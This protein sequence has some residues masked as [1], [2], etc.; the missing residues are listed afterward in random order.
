MGFFEDLGDAIKDG[1]EYAAEAIGETIVADDSDLLALTTCTDAAAEFVKNSGEAIKNFALV[2]NGE[3]SALGPA[4]EETGEA[5]QNIL[6]E[7]ANYGKFRWLGYGAL[8]LQAGDFVATAGL[9]GEWYRVTHKGCGGG[10]TTVNA[11][12]EGKFAA[13]ALGIAIAQR[14]QEIRSVEE[15]DAWHSILKQQGM[16]GLAPLWTEVKRGFGDLLAVKQGTVSTEEGAKLPAGLRLGKR[17]ALNPELRRFASAKTITGLGTRTNPPPAEKAP[18]AK[19]LVP[20][21]LSM[22]AFL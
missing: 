15:L 1:V 2:I 18:P 21:L 22:L 3:V 16:D 5:I 10:R 14:A 7:V 13:R 8:H 17:R 6:E 20:A 11:G 19:W 9:P 12:T 4:L